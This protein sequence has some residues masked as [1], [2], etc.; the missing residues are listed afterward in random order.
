MTVMK[1]APP[2]P[3]ASHV[4]IVDDE[5]SIC[6]GLKR[7]LSEEGHRVSVT[8]SA[9]EAL[10]SVERQVP[11]LVVM[12]V[13]LPGMD[14]LS[15]ME[16]LSSVSGPIPVV[17]MT[18][19]GSL[20]TAVAAMKRGAIDYLTKPFELDEAAEVIRRALGRSLIQN[21]G[22]ALRE[23]VRQW[24]TARLWS[25][26]NQGTLYDAFLAE[27]EPPLF[28]TVLKHTDHSRVA[29]AD[30]LGIHRATLRKKLS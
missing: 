16:R 23:A 28:E 12:D 11:D 24:A 18:A 17:V 10:V 19:F 14:G 22:A 25:A 30:L 2:K 20:D 13:R 7:L 5:E 29:A 21:R 1:L 9:E 6:W 27:V 8:S 3:D 4:L 26:Q 15:A